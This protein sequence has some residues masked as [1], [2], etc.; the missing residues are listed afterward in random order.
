M[1][2][3]GRRA[4]FGRARGC[5]LWPLT[6]ILARRARRRR[7]SLWRQVFASIATRASTRPDTRGTIATGAIRQQLEG[8]TVLDIG[9]FDGFYAFRSRPVGPEGGGC[10]NG[11]TSTGSGPGGA[12]AR[13]RRGL[14][15]DPRG[16][17]LK[18][19]TKAR[20]ARA[21][22]LTQDCDFIFK[23]S[24]IGSRHRRGSSR[25]W[26]G[27]SKGGWSCSSTRCLR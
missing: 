22:E 7:G 15:S 6:S 24:S 27:V 25:C 11:S 16:A 3:D 1:E 2:G 19:G 4:H 21:D 26:A 12:R 17:G 5:G 14:S 20:C 10:G 13:G 9:T 23:A 8:L 18:V